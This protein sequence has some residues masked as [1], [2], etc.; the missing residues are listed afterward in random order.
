MPPQAIPLAKGSRGARRHPFAGHFACVHLLRIQQAIEEDRIDSAAKANLAVDCNDRHRA[1]VLCGQL[2]AEVH[3]HF[4]QRKSMPLLCCL[5]LLPG[6]LAEVTTAPRVEDKMEMSQSWPASPAP[7]GL[8]TEKT[9][10][11]HVAQMLLTGS[12]GYSFRPVFPVPAGR[13][14]GAGPDPIVSTSSLCYLNFIA[15]AFGMPSL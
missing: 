11:K 12:V 2:G 3:V 10:S 1:A 4:F 8:Y 5:D 14:G 13:P 7:P 6:N 15:P 9:N